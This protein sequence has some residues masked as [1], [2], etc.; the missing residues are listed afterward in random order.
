[1]DLTSPPPPRVLSTWEQAVPG[2]PRGL[3][4]NWAAHGEPTLVWLEFTLMRAGRHSGACSLQHR[5]N[6]PI[7]R[8]VSI[9]CLYKRLGEGSVTYPEFPQLR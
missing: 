1:M 9:I 8:A 2:P 4:Q 6:R 3:R 5:E 7:M